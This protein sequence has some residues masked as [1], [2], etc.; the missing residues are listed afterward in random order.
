MQLIAFVRISCLFLMSLSSYASELTVPANIKVLQVNDEHFSMDLFDRSTTHQLKKGR[1]ELHFQYKELIEDVENDDH[2]TIYSKP[3]VV[4][5]TLDTIQRLTLQ[6]P[7]FENEQDIR[8]FAKQPTVRIVNDDQQE[9]DIYQQDLKR[10][11]TQQ[12][13]NLT[14][15]K[16]RSYP[17]TQ[18]QDLLNV[19]SENKADKPHSDSIHHLNDTMPLTMLHYWWQ[20]ASKQQRA[21][22]LREI[23]RDLEKG[24]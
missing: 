5:L 15:Q 10:F 19:V 14:L 22:F 13:V 21:E 3:F 16:S 2:T 6:V 9:I 7:S 1:N 12:D 24:K 8:L 20:H 18:Q 11:Q 23:N 4:L 17:Q